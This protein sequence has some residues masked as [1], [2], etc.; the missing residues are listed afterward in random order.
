MMDFGFSEKEMIDECLPF[1][2]G[3]GDCCACVNKM[4]SIIC[5]KN[6]TIERKVTLSGFFNSLR[7]LLFATLERKNFFSDVVDFC[8][9][10]EST[11]E[12][13]RS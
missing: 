12:C 13:E 3:V 7:G 11:L 4:L 9:M 2:P 6:Y 8:V 10:S 1:T 5:A